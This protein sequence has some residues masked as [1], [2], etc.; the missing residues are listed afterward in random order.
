MKP[1]SVSK[2]YA[3]VANERKPITS[4][5]NQKMRPSVIKKKGKR[6]L[7]SLKVAPRPPFRYPEDKP[8][9]LKKILT[10]N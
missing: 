2:K 1:R 5:K 7:K 6:A 4:G 3:W 10:L 8:N 9:F